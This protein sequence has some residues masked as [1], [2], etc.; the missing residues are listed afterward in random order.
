MSPCVQ[1]VYGMVRARR[2]RTFK[3]DRDKKEDEREGRDGSQARETA[4]DQDTGKLSRR[5]NPI[6]R[7]IRRSHMALTNITSTSVSTSPG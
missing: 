2:R 7:S 1:V 3:R 5:H 6:S 4:G